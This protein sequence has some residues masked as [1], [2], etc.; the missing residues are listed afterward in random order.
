MTR[1]VLAAAFA[2]VISGF[3]IAPSFAEDPIAITIVIK[4]HKF[5]PAELKVPAGKVIE[6][7]VDNQD[8]TP[9]EFE[10]AD[11]QGRENHRWQPKGKVRFGPLAGHLC[12]H[13][14]VQSGDGPRRGD[15]GVAS[16]LGP[17]S[18]SCA[19]FSKPA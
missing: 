6:L 11:P 10:L 14:R 1:A 17:S 8:P 12:L 15:G 7:M 19:R 9:E 5:D 2:V 16:V 3:L 4:D 13:R 18:S